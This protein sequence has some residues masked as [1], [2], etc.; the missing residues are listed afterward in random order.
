MKILDLSEILMGLSALLFFIYSIWQLIGGSG[1]FIDYVMLVSS[2]VL[3]GRIVYLVVKGRVDPD[4][5]RER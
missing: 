5:R 1:T 3:L 2:L 4:F